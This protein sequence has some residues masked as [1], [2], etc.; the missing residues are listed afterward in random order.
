MHNFYGKGNKDFYVI[1]SSDFHNIFFSKIIGNLSWDYDLSISKC[2]ILS[3]E[4][5]FAFSHIY[6]SKYRR[7]LNNI[8]KKKS[9]LMF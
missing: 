1:Y 4:S 7:Y 8:K 3:T 6:R 2:T 9:N 5:W